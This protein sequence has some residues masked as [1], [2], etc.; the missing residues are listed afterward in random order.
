M[1]VAASFHISDL[2]RDISRADS[3]SAARVHTTRRG[4]P[5]S[6]FEI[7]GKELINSVISSLDEHQ[8]D[9]W[10]WE[11]WFRHAYTT[12]SPTFGLRDLASGS[13]VGFASIDQSAIVRGEPPGIIDLELEITSVYIRPDF[14]GRGYGSSLR[15]AAAD[16]LRSVLEGIAAMS[17][18]EV[19]DL[20]LSGLSITV[21]SYPESHE[22]QA[23]AQRLYSVVSDHLLTLSERAWFG[24]ATLIDETTPEET[25][26]VT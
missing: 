14:R 18:D 19:K 9:D 13:I 24:V 22:G 23:F 21:S 3:I 8:D 15:E 2:L 1:T 10:E 7:R 25:P 4:N 12:G 20:G 16:Y 6:V 17:D 5:V 26:S 11:K